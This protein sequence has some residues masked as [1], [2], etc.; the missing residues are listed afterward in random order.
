MNFALEYV[1]RKMQ[2]TGDRLAR[3]GAHHPLFYGDRLIDWV[4]TAMLK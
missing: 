4:K 2:E 1:S 3:S